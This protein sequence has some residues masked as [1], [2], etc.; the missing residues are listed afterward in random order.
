[1][2]YK[3]AGFYTWFAVGNTKP[4]WKFM[5]YDTNLKVHGRNHNLSK[6]YDIRDQFPKIKWVILFFKIDKSAIF[7]EFDY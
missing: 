5:I 1:M 2:L 3:L 7:E 4:I 6:V